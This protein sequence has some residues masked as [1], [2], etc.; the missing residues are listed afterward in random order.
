MFDT[1]VFRNIKTPQDFAREEQEFMLRK[2]QQEIQ[3]QMGEIGLQ[4]AQQDLTAPKMP[5][6]GTSWDAQSANE[7]Y[8]YNLSRGMSEDEA[9]RNAVDMVLKTKVDT[10][11]VTDPYTGQVTYQATP[12]TP[13][14][15]GEPQGIPNQLFPQQGQGSVNQQYQIPPMQGGMIDE[16]LVAP[17]MPVPQD[18]SQLPD[19]LPQDIMA[20]PPRDAMNVPNGAFNLD[21]RAFL[22]PDVQKKMAEEQARKQLEKPE[23]V[24]MAEQAFMSANADATNIIGLADQMLE[25]ANPLTTGLGG[26]LGKVIPGSGSRDMAENLKTIE[27]D[28]AFSSLQQMRDNSKTGGAL[29]QVSERELGLLSAA[30]AALSQSQSYGQFKQNLARY[31]QIRQDA[32]NRVAEAF[33]KDN[34]FYPRGY[35]KSPPTTDVNTLLD[36][37]VPLGE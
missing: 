29:G 23:Q 20:M 25:E 28:A 24:R 36:K 13:M 27:A 17:A 26:A 2:R 5:F 32:L 9:R 22:S 11:P 10:R 34:G 16:N 7:A 37:Y 6:E 18:V 8:R 4:K 30:K 33:Y 3:S 35:N 15:G 1:S 21:E 19:V 12:R 31:K 14:F